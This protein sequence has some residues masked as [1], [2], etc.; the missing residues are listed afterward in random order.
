MKAEGYR[1]FATG[2]TGWLADRSLKRGEGG[3]P[4]VALE[5]R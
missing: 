2:C 3:L 1:S 5:T 4:E